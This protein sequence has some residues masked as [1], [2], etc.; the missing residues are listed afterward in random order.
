V[1]GVVFNFDAS[2]NDVLVMGYASR[3]RLCDFAHGLIEGA[4]AHYGE[5]VSIEQP[6]YMHRADARCEFRIV[7]RAAA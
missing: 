7:L 3:R 2:S 4:A 5:A 6:R 1:K